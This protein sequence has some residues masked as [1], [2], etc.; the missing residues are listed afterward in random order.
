MTKAQTTPASDT[1]RPTARQTIVLV[2]LMGAGKTTVG[3]R[4]ASDLGLE[5][6][7]ADHEIEKAAGCT[8]PQIFETYGEAAFREGERKV[9]SRLL[10]D[11]PHVLAT[12]GGAFM[13]DETRATIKDRAVSVWLDAE[14]PILLERVSRKNNRPLLKTGDPE[15]IL[16][17]LAAERNPIYAEADIRVESD[18]GAHEIVVDKIVQ[19]LADWWNESND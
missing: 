11:A 19:A 13:N 14:I 3:R 1:D 7:D 18:G 12:G 9:I 15:T 2:G 8:I 17:K 4:L 6:R 5:F 16:R 10:D